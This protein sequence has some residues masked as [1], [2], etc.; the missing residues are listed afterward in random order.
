LEFLV[1]KCTIWQTCSP[2][3][4]SDDRCHHIFSSTI[5]LVGQTRFL[6]RIFRWKSLVCIR[7]CGFDVVLSM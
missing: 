7:R 1:C 4:N 6:L 2:V 3:K 5:F